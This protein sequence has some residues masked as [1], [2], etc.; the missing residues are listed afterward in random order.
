M[1]NYLS[2]EKKEAKKRKRRR[3]VMV[4]LAV[5][6]LVL[7]ILAVIWKPGSWQLSLKM[8]GDP[9]VTIDMGDK[10]SDA[11][12]EAFRT[13]KFLKNMKKDVEVKKTGKV[14][15]NKEGTYTITYSASYHDQKAEKKR[16]VV[17]K[18]ENPIIT[19]H[20]G[21]DFTVYDTIGFK[22]S[23]SAVD[24]NGNDLTGSVEYNS[25]LDTTKPGKYEIH[26]W[27]KDSE[28]HMGRAIRKITVKKFPVPEI[29]P[30]EQKT[31]YLTFDD[32]P[33]KYTD[34]LLD[35][36]ARHNV[37]A[38]FFVTNAY[39]QYAYDIKKEAEAGHAVGIHTYSHDYGKV[40]ASDEAFWQDLNDMQKVI[41]QQTGKKT[42]ITRFPG[43]GSN[44]VSA[45]YSP[46]LMIRLANELTANGYWYFDWNVMSGDAGETRDPV[47]IQARMEKGVS[48]ENRSIILCHDIHPFTIAA[49]EPFITW[50]QSN[51]YKFETLKKGDFAAHQHIN[52]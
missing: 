32:G 33:Y 48:E 15:V 49:M 13:N 24:I 17:V 23:Y 25:N 50:A 39:P 7:I 37:K 11:G 31:I 28:G 10:Y 42:D 35:I 36:L 30:V 9:K 4:I 41:E 18:N 14:D 19:L 43:G 12:S 52:N 3:A 45:K 34:Q 47:Q 20:G 29:K 1:E 26:Y 46:G 16:T 6:I 27:V 2:F 51:G 38:T 5:V 44:T 40:Y 8:K 22:D 21:K